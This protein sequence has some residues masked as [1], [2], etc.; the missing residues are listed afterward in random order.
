MLLNPLSGL[1]PLIA[2]QH[3][4][5]CLVLYKWIFIFLFISPAKMVL[6]MSNKHTTTLQNEAWQ[7]RVDVL[8]IT[9]GWWSSVPTGRLWEVPLQATEAC[10]EELFVCTGAAFSGSWPLEEW[11][12]SL[13]SNFWLSATS[14]THVL[15]PSPPSFR[16]SLV[17]PTDVNRGLRGTAEQKLDSR[18]KVLLLYSSSVT[19]KSCQSLQG[20]FLARG[21]RTWKITG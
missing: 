4:I 6:F 1:A 11:H 8:C 5:L 3:H 12:R 7:W 16:R 2:F 10:W 15:L 19:V 14:A 21:G 20:V 18:L 13:L 9:A 17:P